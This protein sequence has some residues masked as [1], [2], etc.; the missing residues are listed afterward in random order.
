MPVWVVTGWRWI[1]LRHVEGEAP[2]G[3]ASSDGRRW[4]RS[5]RLGVL[6]AD[7]NVVLG[8]LAGRLEDLR[9]RGEDGSGGVGEGSSLCQRRPGCYWDGAEGAVVVDN[10]DIVKVDI[11]VGHS[12]NVVHDCLDPHGRWG[13]RPQICAAIGG[14][15]GRTA[16]R[17]AR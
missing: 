7:A 3:E 8:L 9:R 5:L 16:R 12:R 6:V 13:R 10:G 15:G 2:D 17:N 4:K 11:N 1:S 14:P